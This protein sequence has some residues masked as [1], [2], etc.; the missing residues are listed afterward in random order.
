MTLADALSIALR[1]RGVSD[2]RLANGIGVSRIYAYKVVVGDARPAE[3]TVRRI[4]TFL[5]MEAGALLRYSD[6]V[7]KELLRWG[8]ATPGTGQLLRHL[9]DHGI[10]PGEVL[11]RLRGEPPAVATA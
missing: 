6:H 10:D 7:D 2:A 11:T 8:Q 4:E 1:E 3:A 9:R 5:A